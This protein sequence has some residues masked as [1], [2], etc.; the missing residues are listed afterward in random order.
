MQQERASDLRRGQDATF[1]RRVDCLLA[2]N[3]AWGAGLGGDGGDNNNSG[4]RIKNYARQFISGKGRD[5]ELWK[6]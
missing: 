3:R 5:Q 6:R 1:W 4:A 2:K